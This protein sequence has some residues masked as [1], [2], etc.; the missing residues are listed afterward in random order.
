MRAKFIRGASSREQIID[1]LLDRII[2]IE[3]P[4]SDVELKNGDFDIRYGNTRDFV[5]ELEKTGISFEPI[6][7]DDHYVYVEL[8]GTKS[9]LISAFPI[10]DA[11]GRD[12]DELAEALEDWEGDLK[13]LMDILT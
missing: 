7:K 2:T 12:S 6:V 10:W 11:H 13:Q 1:N 9:Q 4:T 3:M 5:E 8:S